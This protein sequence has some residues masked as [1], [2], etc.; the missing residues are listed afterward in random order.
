MPHKR[1]ITITLAVL[2]P[3]GACLWFAWPVYQFFAYKG[4]APM[5]AWGYVTIPTEGPS[6]ST[7][8]D[9]TYRQAAARSLKEISRHRQAIQAPA[10]SAAVAIQ[11]K[12]VW[13]G[14]VGWA[15]IKNKVAVT[16]QTRFRIGSVSKPLTITALAQL[17]ADGTVELDAPITRYLPELPNRQWHNITA[18]Q[19]A[20]HTAGL[21]EYKHTAEWAGLYRIM[22]LQTHYEDVENSLAIFDDTPLAFEPGSDFQYTSY[23]TVLLSAVMQSA[24]GKPYQQLMQERVMTPLQMNATGADPGE[25]RE[26]MA[27]FYWKRGDRAKLWRQ[28]DLSHRLAG[29]GFV[30]TPSDLVKLGSAWLDTGFIPTDVR[31]RFWQPQRLGS[32]ELNPQNYALGWRL[33]KGDDYM[34]TNLNHGGVSRGAQCWLMVIPEYQMSIAISMNS[35][36][37]EFWEFGELAIF[38][39]RH[40]IDAAKETDP[41]NE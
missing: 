18:R 19:L 25:H 12:R 29:G 23:G 38:I 31:E 34:A 17:V 11:G 15:D 40:F 13:A 7:L 5:P 27:R 32:G 1:L 3:L 24:A 9:D 21:V 39:A 33:H 16:P 35:K 4:D 37:G 6:S 10:L 22:A 20:S 14:A 30:S 8:D 36:V 2:L 41:V 26:P 28:V